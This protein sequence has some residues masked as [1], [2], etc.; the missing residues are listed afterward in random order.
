[1]Q[2]TLRDWKRDHAEAMNRL[3]EL[4]GE[5]EAVRSHIEAVEAKQGEIAE[6]DR[7]EGKL[8]GEL[9]D[10]KAQFAHNLFWT[11]D[12]GAGVLEE[13]DRIHGEMD[14]VRERRAA[15]VGEL[16][17]MEPIDGEAARA[18]YDA[19]DNVD[20]PPRPGGILEEAGEEALLELV[21]ACES[22]QSA[23]QAAYP[24]DPDGFHAPEREADARREK[25]YRER[26]DR[27]HEEQEQE[28]R[29]QLQKLREK[30]YRVRLGGEPSNPADWVS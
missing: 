13:R 15:L 25:A 27:R 16:E 19:A 24:H 8:Q 2:A 12:R 3:E 11:T 22:V 7:R 30:G 14:D 26:E 28:R 18:L 9:E 1:M 6:L 29:R 20:F 23:A 17:A 4:Q 5:A 21:E 10:C